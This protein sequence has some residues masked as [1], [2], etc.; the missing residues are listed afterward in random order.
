MIH[1][2]ILLLGLSG[3]VLAA[4]YAMLTQLRHLEDGRV[5]TLPELQAYLE[6][7]PEPWLGRPLRVW[8]LAQP[9]PVWGSPYSS[10]HCARMQPEL[11]DPDS[12]AL[13]SPLLLAG[14]PDDPVHG[15]LR[16]L[17][18]IGQLLPV[19]RLHWER[20]AVYRVRLRAQSGGACIGPS[21]YLAVLLDAAS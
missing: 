1:R 4:C 5:Y 7:Q 19:Q 18:L 13:G 8:A 3:L 12:S 16:G 21:C 15:L 20:P 2:L 10:V 9:C 17:P 6:Q 11:V 14:E